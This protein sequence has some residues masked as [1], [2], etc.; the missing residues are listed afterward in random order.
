VAASV[1]VPYD[2]PTVPFGNVG[3]VVIPGGGAM[4]IENCC[5]DDETCRVSV[6]TTPKLNWPAV[7]GV[8]LINPVVVFRFSP[9]GNVLG[10]AS[11]Q[12]SDP[13]PPDAVNGCE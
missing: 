13:V 12:V 10:L 4:V 9:G 1:T 6:T 7:L 8:P 5:G 2:V 3:A 11:D